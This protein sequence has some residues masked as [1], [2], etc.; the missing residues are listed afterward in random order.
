MKDTRLNSKEN[1]ENK[2]EKGEGRRN[3]IGDDGDSSWILLSLAETCSSIFHL[4]FRSL[5]GYLGLPVPLGGGNLCAMEICP[6]VI[7][8]PT[9]R[10]ERK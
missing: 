5:P 7:H 2:R 6:G 8:V 4:A 9:R 3:L 1:Q 10:F